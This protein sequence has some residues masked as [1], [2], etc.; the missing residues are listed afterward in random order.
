MQYAYKLSAADDASIER[1]T[2]Y[3]IAE[4][5][6]ALTQG[7]RLIERLKDRFYTQSNAALSLSPVGGHFRH[8]VDFYQSFL[9]GLESG[10]INYDHRERDGRIEENRLFAAARLNLI[11]ESLNRLSEVEGRK[12]IE[13][14]LEGSPDDESGSNWSRSSLMREL[15]FLLSHTIHHYSLIALALRMQGFEPGV[16]FG[17]APS[18]LKHWRTR[19]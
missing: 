15:Q 4:N 5:I 9:A 12:R 3:L 8:C 10:R 13:V 14:I 1:P 2:G 17:V 19:A 18:T 16:E 7:V 11:I 6:E